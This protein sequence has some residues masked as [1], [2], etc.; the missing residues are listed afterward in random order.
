MLTIVAATLVHPMWAPLPNPLNSAMLSAAKPHLMRR[1]EACPQAPCLSRL[2]ATHRARSASKGPPSPR[3]SRKSLLRLIA[4]GGNNR[5]QCRFAVPRPEP[6]H[7]TLSVALPRTE[8]ITA[9]TL[10]ARWSKAQ[11]KASQELMLPFIHSDSRW[12]T[13]QRHA[14]AASPQRAANS[15]RG[16]LRRDQSQKKRR[17]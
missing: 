10:P 9:T 17:S 8:S 13:T 6:L 11:A 15:L 14:P 3:P 1:R 16:S 4:A 7:V 2:A 5:T 12:P